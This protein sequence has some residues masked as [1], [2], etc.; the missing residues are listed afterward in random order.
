MM[1]NRRP[2]LI[3]LGGT[4]KL[5]GGREPHGIPLLAARE[6]FPRVV[7]F[8][9]R[10]VA[11]GQKPVVFSAKRRANQMRTDLPRFEDLALAVIAIGRAGL[12]GNDGVEAL[13]V[14]KHLPAQRPVGG[15]LDIHVAILD[16]AFA[17]LFFQLGD[18]VGEAVED[19]H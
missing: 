4:A 10:R 15:V 12:K 14:I 9:G 1:A 7:A 13:L 17:A 11:G 5:A 8:D 19:G 18:G 16:K 2:R 6:R 3:G